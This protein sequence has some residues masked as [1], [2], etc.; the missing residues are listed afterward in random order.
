MNEFIK[1]TLVGGAII[2]I[3]LVLLFWFAKILAIIALLFCFLGLSHA[4]GT[5]FF[6]SDEDNHGV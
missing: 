3:L 2:T 4:T 5:L 1:K 6:P